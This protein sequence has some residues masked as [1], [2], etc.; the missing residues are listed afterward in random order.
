MEWSD[1]CSEE[2]VG[3]FGWTNWGCFVESFVSDSEKT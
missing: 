2:T 3:S 1:P